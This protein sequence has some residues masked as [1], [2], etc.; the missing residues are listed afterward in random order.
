M[1]KSAHRGSWFFERIPYERIL[2]YDRFRL[3]PPFRRNSFRF[4]LKGP[5]PRPAQTPLLYLKNVT[6]GF[7]GTTKG[8]GRIPK[9]YQRFCAHYQRFC[10]PTF[11]TALPLPLARANPGCLPKVGGTVGWI[12]NTTTPIAAPIEQFPNPR[13]QKEK[14]TLIVA[15]V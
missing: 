5:N 2:P 11:G 10:P 7:V 6:K 3:I 13:A 9:N 12:P 4:S 15:H 1:R 8:R 14:N